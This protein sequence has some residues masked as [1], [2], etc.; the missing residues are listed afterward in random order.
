MAAPL[1]ANP[2]L[3]AVLQHQTPAAA[4]AI[5]IM[6][7]SHQNGEDRLLLITF[8]RMCMMSM[9][10]LLLILIHSEFT[11]LKIEKACGSFASIL[12]TSMWLSGGQ[13]E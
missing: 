13:L 2:T 8:T 5:V 3:L 7:S 6:C 11:C 10:F 12:V 9:S 4:S 1:S